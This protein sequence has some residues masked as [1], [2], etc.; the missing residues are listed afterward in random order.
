MKSLFG[1]FK[2]TGAVL[3]LLCSTLTS[4]TQAANVCR[5]AAFSGGG[6]K[7][8][9]EAGAVY[10]FNNNGNPADFA[11]DV[12]TGVSAGALN[13]AGISLWAPKDGLAMSDWLV[14]TWLSLTNDKVYVSWPGGFAQGL[15]LESGVYDNTPL[16]NLITGFFNT[17]GSLKRKTVVS[18]VDINTG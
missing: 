1:S 7:G 15:T 13:S 10:G 5:A 18:S 2:I 4:F 17:F 6:S 16:L 9:Y 8:A 11:W 3:L 12:V 14:N